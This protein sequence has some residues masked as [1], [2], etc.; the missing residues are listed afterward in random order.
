M[1][2]A[3]IS[4]CD[5]KYFEQLLNLYNSLI[6]NNCLDNADFCFVN[7]SVSDENLKKISSKT[8]K[9]VEPKWD[10]KL[11]FKTEDWKKILTIRPF[12]KNYFPGYEYYIWL[13][14][15]TW[16]QGNKFISEFTSVGE[17]GKMSIIP[18]LDINYEVLRQKYSFKKIFYNF[19]KAKGWSYKNYKKYFDKKTDINLF[20]KPILNAGVYSI[21]K[22]S[23]IWNLWAKEYGR[24]V[25]SSSNDYCLNMDQ[26][27]L[28]KVIYNNLDLTNFFGS[29]YNYLA[30]NSMPL[31]HEDNNYFCMKDYPYKKIEILHLTNLKFNSF[32]EIVSNNGVKLKK[33]IIY[34]S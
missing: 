4:G 29:E 27:S 2:T 30:K 14:A 20:Q 7:I 18:E 19:Y 22:N 21:P 6:G 34:E 16:T 28:N 24:I 8:T 26:A 33:K 25:E 10:F 5:N 12:L 13:D 23:N 15:D 11:K 32:Y 1:K 31:F 3:I 17:C 9:I